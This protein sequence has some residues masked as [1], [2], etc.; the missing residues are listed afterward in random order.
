[1]DSMQI[2]KTTILLAILIGISLPMYS[3]EEAK[4]YTLSTGVSKVVL[5]LNRLEAKK[6]VQLNTAQNI[7]EGMGYAKAANMFKSNTNTATADKA[8]WSKLAN[9]ARLNANYEEAAYWYQKVTK[10]GPL[11]KD[12]L[13]YAQALQATGN[14]AEAVKWFNKYNASPAENK[15]A[16]IKNCND[17]NQFSNF[18][19]VSFNTL[20]G[21]NTNKLDFSARPFKEGIVFTSNRGSNLFSRLIDNW[22]NNGFTDLYYAKKNEDGYAKPTLFKGAVNGKFHDGV[23]AFSN[24]DTAMYFTRNDNSRKSKVLNLKIYKVTN[25]NGLSWSAAN[26]LPI[27]GEDF[28]TCHPTVSEDGSTMYFASDR[29]GGYGGMDIYKVTFAD[30]SWGAPQNVGPSINT[31][32]NEI[33]PFL[34]SEGDLAFSSNGHPGMGGLDVFVARQSNPANNNWGRMV[35]AGKPFNSM[36]DDFGF[37]MDKENTTGYMSSGRVGEQSND[38]IYEWK[39]DTKVDF[40]PALSKEQVFCLVDK[41]TGAPIRNA[42]IDVKQS[43]KGNNTETEIKTDNKGQFA[44]T[45]WPT[46]SLTLAMSKD[47]FVDGNKNINFNNMKDENSSCINVE[48]K[49]E[50]VLSIIG[51]VVNK[52]NNDAKVRNASITIFNKCTKEETVFT[53]NNRGEFKMDL[54][55]NCDYRIVGEKDTFIKHSKNFKGKCNEKNEIVLSLRKPKKVVK[56]TPPPTFNNTALVTGNTIALDNINYDYNKS[57]IRPDAEVELRKVITLMNQYPQLTIELGS[58]TDARGSSEYNQKLSASRAESARQYLITK[59]VPADRITSRGYG[60]SNLIN[61]C[62]GNTTCTDEEHEINRRTEIKVIKF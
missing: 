34:T 52:D 21:L 4:D 46:T 22:T 2:I 43:E 35:N 37:Y 58:H 23:A 16:F 36:K 33:F 51:T 31:A 18:D 20:E 8:V 3:Q 41:K 49:K 12:L 28:S 30:G 11:P 45:V 13:H 27:N 26:E 10:D 19:Q 44:L 59:G 25:T 6:E 38:D 15:V 14:C 17:L 24:D 32:G 62:S 1:M 9:A 7:Y 42:Q 5:A 61:H 47:G 40:F 57:S 39:S 54:P 53:S 50:D 56:P 29:P 60:E 48:L 55:C